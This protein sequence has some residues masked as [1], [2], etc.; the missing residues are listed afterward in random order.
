[1]T[2][3]HGLLGTGTRLYDAKLESVGSE[4]TVVRLDSGEALEWRIRPAAPGITLLAEGAG[5]SIQRATVALHAR[6]FD[7]ALRILH[8]AM[9]KA[10]KAGEAAELRAALA[11]LHYAWAQT[12]LARRAVPDAV[13][14]LEAA[15]EIDRAERPWQ[16]GED[17]NEIGFAW[18]AL[19]EPERAV[20]P[21]RQALDLVRTADLRNEPRA[22][23]C[24]RT[25]PRSSWIEP[26][27]LNGLANAERARGRLSEARDLY[28]RALPLWRAVGDAL[29]ASAALTGLGLVEQAL[30]QPARALKLHR[31]ALNVPWMEPAARGAI[32]NN[33]GS[34]QL[35]AGRRDEA[36]ASFD[37]ALA[38]YRLL[39]DRAGEGTVLNNIGALSEARAEMAEACAAYE[40]ALGA[41]R[42]GDD[43][44]GEAITRARIERLVARGRAGD[45]ALASCREALA[46]RRE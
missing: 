11:D 44:R 7:D 13:R 37:A 43:R 33:L 39:G 31:Q 5:Q 12:L 26:S 22:G 42:D 19:G 15:Y 45:A 17:L 10:D 16:A 46:G 18:A 23:S 38:D 4:G 36:M 21:H 24:V 27:A 41:S 14:H 8:A 30:G 2:T 40:Q 32:L 28:Q 6:E 34:A 29:G 3:Q 9:A 25:H 20:G 1:M 35:S